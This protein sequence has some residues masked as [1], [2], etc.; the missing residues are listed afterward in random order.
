MCYGLPSCKTDL[1]LWTSPVAGFNHPIWVLYQVDHRPAKGHHP[2][3]WRYFVEQ[4]KYLTFH[5]DLQPGEGLLWYN[6]N[7]VDDVEPHTGPRPFAGAHDIV[8]DGSGYPDLNV[9]WKFAAETK[10][11]HFGTSAGFL[12]ANMNQYHPASLLTCNT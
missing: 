6:H 12:L 10:M 8:Y 1:P 9:L 11:N 5:K 4:L 3:A 2:F 7:G